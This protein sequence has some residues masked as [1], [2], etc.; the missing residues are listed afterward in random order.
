MELIL[1]FFI[2]KH[3]IKN[4]ISE[5][6]I[7]M[8]DTKFNELE[9]NVTMSNYKQF[10]E[11][12]KKNLFNKVN[13]WQFILENLTELNDDFSEFYNL[14]FHQYDIDVSRVIFFELYKFIYIQY[15]E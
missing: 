7:L 14:F 8:F 6:D 1:N 3:K 9:N 5:E 4:E 11:I 12:Y 15:L 13:Q 10:I 2:E